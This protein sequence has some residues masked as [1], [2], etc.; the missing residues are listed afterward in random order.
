MSARKSQQIRDGL[1]IA[2]GVSLVAWL[3]VRYLP[4]F[5]TGTQ[6]LSDFRIANF[7][8]PRPQNDDIVI[9]TITEDTLA[10]FPYRSP[11]QRK[12]IDGLLR[13]LDG[14]EPRAVGLDLIFDQATIAEEDDLLRESMRSLRNPL[15]VAVGD[16]RAGFT[17]EQLDF[18]S[19]FLKGVPVG[20][21]NLPKEDGMIRSSFDGRLVD[22]NMIHSFAYRIASAVG[23]APPGERLRLVYGR[24]DDGSP[25]F[26]QYPAH[27]AH[28]LPREWLAGKIIL[29]GADLPQ[30]DRHRSP[31]ALQVGQSQTTTPGVVIHAHILAQ[32]LDAT[33][34]H[35]LA[36]GMETT[37]LLAMVLFGVLLAFSAI[38]L[39]FKLAAGAAILGLFW[40][41]G[42]A[43]YQGGGP[44]VPLLAPT[45]GFAL[46]LGIAS[47]YSGR[48]ER[49]AKKFLHKAFAQ[50]LNPKLVERLVENPDQ[51]SLGGE[52]REM[53]FIFTDIKGFTSLSETLP[54]EQSVSILQDY[55]DGMVTVAH[56][57][58]G[59]IDKFIGDAVVVI[60]GAPTD[61]PD[62]AQR[63]LEC[64]LAMDA[65]AD[66]FSKRL[67][68]DGINFGLTRIG[69][70]TGTAIVG[71]IGGRLRFEYTAVGD[72]VNTAARLES[73]NNHFGTRLC[74][75]G[76]IVRRCKGIALR[77]I[78]EVVLKGKEQAIDL[79]TSH[80]ADT[81][82]P[83]DSY[84]AIYKAVAN[85]DQDAL[86]QLETLAVQYPHDRLISFHC[87][88]LRGGQQGVFIKM[89]TK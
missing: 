11:V 71:N 5:A 3:A 66:D 40:Y 51:L 53:S 74:V 65:F 54:P 4:V 59:T 28:L 81:D 61:Q 12:F 33:T 35:R 29:V 76:E 49:E 48:R 72:T 39:S 34:F 75:S 36:A 86:Q 70:H 82:A 84:E 30:G 45:L 19:R 50:Y 26:R 63:A 25:M 21:A 73:V 37:N 85:K 23:V 17:T 43:I 13:H 15:V 57:Y 64:A 42:F 79:Y 78:A 69:A 88:R 56:D 22:G 77:P 60:F 89:E 14:Q 24:T 41:F 68:A 80:N 83:L 55:L 62:H 20:L 6:W 16:R 27:T 8:P 32:I 87:T 9:L 52:V 58:S 18:Q 44:M 38:R 7:S 31:L 1:I 47:A 10:T 2:I 67:Q 46:S